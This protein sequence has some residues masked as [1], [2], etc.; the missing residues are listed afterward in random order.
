MPYI[1]KY[2]LCFIRFLP[3]AL[4][5]IPYLVFVLG[6]TVDVLNGHILVCASLPNLLVEVYGLEKLG[7]HPRRIVW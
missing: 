3:N 5:H 4:N 7:V 2:G 6:N 1:C